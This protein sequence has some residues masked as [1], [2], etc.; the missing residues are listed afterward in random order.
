MLRSL[1][2]QPADMATVN[3]ERLNFSLVPQLD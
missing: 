1:N 2:E 3:T